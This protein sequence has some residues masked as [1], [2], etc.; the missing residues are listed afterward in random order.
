ML[1]LSLGVS[2]YYPIIKHSLK[3]LR[4]KF[5][6]EIFVLL[7]NELSCY[8]PLRRQTPVAHLLSVKETRFK[9]PNNKAMR[10]S[11]MVIIR[12]T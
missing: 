6:F 1:Y 2:R 12:H 7:R 8:R 4:Q 9:N 11:V 3:A 5:A 10:Y